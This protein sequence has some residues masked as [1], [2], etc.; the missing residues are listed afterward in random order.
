[1]NGGGGIGKQ[2]FFQIL[3]GVFGRHGLIFMFDGTAG[4]KS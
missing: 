4:S 3:R 2:E 1:M